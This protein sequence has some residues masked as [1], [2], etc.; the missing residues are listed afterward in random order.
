MHT[1]QYCNWFHQIWQ[2]PNNYKYFI[3]LKIPHYRTQSSLSFQQTNKSIHVS[4]S[5]FLET[6]YLHATKNN[7]YLLLRDIILWLYPK[8]KMKFLFWDQERYKIT[9]TYTHA[10]IYLQAHIY[11]STSTKHVQ[12]SV[13]PN[14][15]RSGTQTIWPTNLRPWDPLFVRKWDPTLKTMSILRKYWVHLA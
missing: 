6:H 3:R 7:I 5:T 4:N 2:Q 14:K 9:H 8:N 1:K 12:I 10:Y 13:I 11:W 15:L